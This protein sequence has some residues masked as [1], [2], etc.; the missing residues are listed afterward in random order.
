M[1]SP[2]TGIYATCLGGFPAI[3][4]TFESDQFVV[5]I[6]EACRHEEQ[7]MFAREPAKAINFDSALSWRCMVWE[8]PAKAE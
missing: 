1:Q 3:K 7:N 8:Q 2:P 6:S 4:A 5:A